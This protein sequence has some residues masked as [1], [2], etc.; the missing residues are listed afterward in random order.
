MHQLAMSITLM[1]SDKT[2]VTLGALEGGHEYQLTIYT[3][4][5][6]GVRVAIDNERSI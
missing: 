2:N 3:D 4:V 5:W 6:E 1:T